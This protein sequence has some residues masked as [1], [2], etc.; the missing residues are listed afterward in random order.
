VKEDRRKKP[1]QGGLQEKA[2]KQEIGDLMKRPLQ[3]LTK[4]AA[5]RMLQLIG[6]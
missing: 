6:N 3:G 1:V 2:A 4:K 5:A